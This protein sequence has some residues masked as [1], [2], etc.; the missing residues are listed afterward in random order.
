MDFDGGLCE[1]VEEKGFHE[2]YMSTESNSFSSPTW[3]NI[4]SSNSI[5][6]SFNCPGKAPAEHRK[7]ISHSKFPTLCSSL[8]HS[9]RSAPIFLNFGNVNPSENPQQGSYDINSENAKQIR[10]TSQPRTQKKRTRPPSQTYDH[11]IAERRRREQLS[12]LF[13][14]LSAIVPG[15]KKTDKT[16]VLGDTIK[17]LQ[18]LQKRVETLEEKAAKRTMEP[19]VHVKKS[20]IVVEDEGSSDEKSGSSGERVQAPEIEARVVN[21]Q[22]LLRIHC[23]KQKGTL[24]NLLSKVESLNLVVVNTSVTPFGTSAQDITIIAEMEK[25]FNMTV[26]EVA[27]ALRASSSSQPERIDHAIWLSRANIDS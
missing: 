12:R 18:H 10:S 16:S 7:S 13:I 27:T 5:I 4:L 26:K 3:I 2:N 20:Q 24:A 22:I 21:N 17:Y 23:G 1:V 19:V 6:S 8:I 11:I 15:L 9:N 25:E 14:A